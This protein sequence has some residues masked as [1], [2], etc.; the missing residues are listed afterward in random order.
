MELELTRTESRVGRLLLAGNGLLHL[1]A[2]GLLLG[3]ASLAYDLALD[4]RFEP[5]EGAR[6]RVRL[7]GAALLAA[8]VATRRRE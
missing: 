7:V 5:G 6:R 8:A 4:V 2:P 3:L 1:L